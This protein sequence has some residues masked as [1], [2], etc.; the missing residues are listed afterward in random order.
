MRWSPTYRVDKPDN[1][2]LRL[3]LRL[4]RRDMMA[5]NILRPWEMEPNLRGQRRNGGAEEEAAAA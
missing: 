4:L 2:R 3:L 5:L 1:D